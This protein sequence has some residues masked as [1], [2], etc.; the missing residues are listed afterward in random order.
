MRA[1]VYHGPAQ[2][3]WDTVPEPRIEED[4]DAIVRVD[5]TTICGSDLRIQRG[6]L[7]R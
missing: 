3:S 5:A 2:T 1:L 6:D 7:P 4:T